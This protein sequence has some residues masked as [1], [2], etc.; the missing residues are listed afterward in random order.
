MLPWML[1]MGLDWVGMFASAVP[2]LVLS[3]VWSAMVGG[4]IDL[5]GF[6]EAVFK[7]EL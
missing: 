5:V 6:G 4:W 7:D 3:E 1:S 2:A